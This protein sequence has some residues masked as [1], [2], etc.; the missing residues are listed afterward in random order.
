MPA[1]A[2]MTDPLAS[3]RRLP[4]RPHPI[5]NQPGKVQFVTAFAAAIRETGSPN[6]ALQ[7]WK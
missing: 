7:R 4:K 1:C 6:P 3:V 5:R 2:G